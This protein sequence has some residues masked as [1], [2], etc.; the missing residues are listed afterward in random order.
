LAVKESALRDGEAEVLQIVRG[1]HK[2]GTVGLRIGVKCVSYVGL[3][4]LKSDEK[5]LNPSTVGFAET[6][7]FGCRVEISHR[8][9][10]LY[11]GD[12]AQNSWH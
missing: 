11:S 6:V 7:N 4:V 8:L 2:A 5:K 1:L 10:V 9:Q 3:A 12:T